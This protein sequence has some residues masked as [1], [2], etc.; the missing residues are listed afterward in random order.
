[1][2]SL[3]GLTVS[4]KKAKKF[5]AY[6]SNGKHTDFGDSTAED[7]LEHHDKSRRE[8]YRLRHRKDLKTD[9]PTRAGYLSWFLLWGDST[10][11]EKNVELYKYLFNM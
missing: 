10:D 4:P 11:L 1:M 5:R 9:D 8:A 7:Y 2:V 6:F 3:V